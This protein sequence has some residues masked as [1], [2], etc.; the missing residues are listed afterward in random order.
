MF[1]SVDVLQS[2]DIR[3]ILSIGH[4]ADIFIGVTIAIV[5]VLLCEVSKE[6]LE[7]AEGVVDGDGGAPDE[8]L[9]VAAQL[10]RLGGVGAAVGEGGGVGAVRGGPLADDAAGVV[11]DDAPRG[12]GGPRQ[13]VGVD[14]P[15]AGAHGAGAGVESSADDEIAEAESWVTETGDWLSATEV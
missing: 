1:Q 9:A 13:A 15:A 8:A 2:F 10:V 7:G 4:A 6:V 12:A 3:L 14:V 5:A 11:Q